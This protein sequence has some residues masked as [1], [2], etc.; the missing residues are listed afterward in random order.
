MNPIVPKENVLGTSITFD[1]LNFAIEKTTPSTDYYQ[2]FD[3]EA[4]KQKHNCVIYTEKKAIMKQK[5]N[6][7]Q[8]TGLKIL[9]IK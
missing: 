9:R 6:F 2:I 1:H 8:K 3:N 4:F 5:N 7:I